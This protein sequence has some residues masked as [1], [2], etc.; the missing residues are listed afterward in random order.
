MPL[1]VFLFHLELDR[2]VQARRFNQTDSSFCESLFTNFII[3]AM[4]AEGKRDVRAVGDD[5]CHCVSDVMAS[6]CSYARLRQKAPGRIL[7]SPQVSLDVSPNYVTL[8]R[9][10]STYQNISILLVRK[11]PLKFRSLIVTK[12]GFLHI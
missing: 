11:P 8:C 3:V 4:T 2:L 1:C 10:L 9:N 12:A 6:V 5:H 7:Q